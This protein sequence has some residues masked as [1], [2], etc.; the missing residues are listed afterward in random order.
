M[1]KYSISS[2]KDLPEEPE[3][4]EY[5]MY[6]GKEVPRFKLSRICGTVLDK[7]KNKNTITLLT[8]DSGVVMVKMNRGTFSRYNSQLSII[9]PDTGKKTVL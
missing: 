6:R 4:V 1:D 7:D 9:N 8:P 5:R 2:F 3:V